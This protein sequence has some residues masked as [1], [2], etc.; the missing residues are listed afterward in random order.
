MNK[1]KPGIPFKSAKLA[2]WRIDDRRLRWVF[3]VVLGL[4][5]FYS[6]L[7]VAARLPVDNY[8]FGDFF[9]IWTWAQV[10]TTVSSTA[11]YDPVLVH[12]AQ[13]SFGL[14]PKLSYPFAYPP[15]FL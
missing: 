12:N 4:F 2:P 15:M 13:V 3:R 11:L 8:R 1:V 14:S 9:A 5:T 6:A 7:Y 10:L